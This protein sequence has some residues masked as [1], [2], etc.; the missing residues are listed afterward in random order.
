MYLPDVNLWLA[1]TWSRHEHHKIASRW[2]DETEAPIY[3]CRITQLSFLRLVT[4]PSVMKDDT[5]TRD[6]AW[7]IYKN[8]LEDARISF[9]DEPDQIQPIFETHSRKSDTA[10]KLWTD[11]YLVSF[12]QAA[13]LTFATFDK[14]AVQR[15]PHSSTLIA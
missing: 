15:Y 2:F 1:A 8:I 12:A 6:Q 13:N 14:A 4:H 11:D 10:H 7:T 9:L 5:R 3:F